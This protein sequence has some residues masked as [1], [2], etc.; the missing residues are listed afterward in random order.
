MPKP[1]ASV[2]AKTAVHTT[3]APA[4][5]GPYSQAIAVGR[6]LWMSGQIALD[7]ATMQIV[8][9]GIEAQATRVLDNMRAVLAAA[10]GKLDDI[11]KLTILLVDLA[12]FAK[13]NE[14][15][16][17]AFKAP[18]PARS[19]YQVAALPRGSRIEVEAVALL[20]G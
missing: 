17:A 12:D 18:Y 4:A 1:P 15:M 11:V 10:G 20:P 8:D 19:T 3:G 7:P 14:L 2:P 13:V 5:I 6:T 9:G 16:A